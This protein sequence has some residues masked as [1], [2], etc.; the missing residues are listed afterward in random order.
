MRCHRWRVGWRPS[1]LHP[2]A[3]VLQG[4]TLPAFRWP[5]LLRQALVPSGLRLQVHRMT[6]KPP[7]ELLLT[8]S[9]I[10]HR[11]PRRTLLPHPAQHLQS[12]SVR[13]RSVPSHFSNST[14]AFSRGQLAR[15]LGTFVP[16]F[17]KARGLRRGSLSP[18]G[19]L[20]RPQ[21]TTPHPPPSK[22]I[23]VSSRVCPFLLSTLLNIAWKAS[24]VQLGR[25]K[26]N[27]TGGVF[28][29]LPHPLSAAPQSLHR[30]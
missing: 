30:G 2:S 15:S 9:G 8:A 19:R 13:S 7:C 14:G 10:Q 4:V 26:R 6:Q 12:V 23:G 25:L 1:S 11:V 24:R 3:R 17:P 22:I 29:S 20:C 5:L 21:T 18:C 16:V 27:D 28:I